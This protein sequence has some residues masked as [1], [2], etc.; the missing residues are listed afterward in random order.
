MVFSNAGLGFNPFSSVKS[1]VKKTA[2]V[3][4]KAHTIPTKFAVKAVVKAHQVPTNLAVRATKRVL[5]KSVANPLTRVL[6]TPT[7]LAIRATNKAVLPGIDASGRLAVKTMTV[8]TNIAVDSTHKTLQLTKKA[9]LATALRPVVTKVNLLKSRRARKLAWDRRKATVPNAAEQAEAKA[10]TKAQLKGKTPPFG[11]MLSM[12]AGA[13]DADQFG[14][15]VAFGSYY[16]ATEYGQ[17]GEPVTAAAVIAAIP[18]LLVLIAAVLNAM[19]KSGAAPATLAPGGGTPEQQAAYAAQ[20]AQD[21]AAAAANPGAI[22]MTQ[23]QDEAAAA[24]EAVASG[25]GGT[26]EGGEAGPGMVK[27]PG[28]STPVKKSHLLLAGVGIG[29]LVLVMVLAGGKKKK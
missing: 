12:L 7:N 16:T 10:W 17:F 14:G 4:V 6:T 20:E 5:P 19:S 23:I 28:V 13:M 18:A 3:V 27:L 8:P 24:D 1:A 15:A 22:D 26:S 29:G 25:D 21:A 9:I 11:F 2:N